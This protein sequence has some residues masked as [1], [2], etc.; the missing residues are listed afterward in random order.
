MYGAA[1]RGIGIPA[2][3]DAI[4]QYLPDAGG[5]PQGALSGI[6]FKIERDKMM[7]RMAYVRVYEGSM[8]NRDIVY[9]HT[10]GIQEKVTQIRKVEGGRTEDLGLLEAGDIAAVCGLTQVRIGDVLGGPE[11]IPP[12]AHLAVPLLTVRVHWANEEQYPLV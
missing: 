11:A 2:L 3:L 12:E 4:V 6:V 9:N 1:S 8:R 10:Q 7:G 5:D